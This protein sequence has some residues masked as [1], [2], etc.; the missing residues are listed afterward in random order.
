MSR[1]AKASATRRLL[2]LLLEERDEVCKI[3][4][5]SISSFANWAIFDLPL[6]S[7]AFLRPPKAILVPGMYFLG[8]CVR[9]QS[10]LPHLVFQ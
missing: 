1:V 3:T 4:I 10:L 6:R 2:G 5:S 9:C 8:F 7:L